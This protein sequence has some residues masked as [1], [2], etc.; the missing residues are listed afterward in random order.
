VAATLGIVV[1]FIGGLTQLAILN[2]SVVRA[3]QLG[4]TPFAALDLVKAFIAAVISGSSTSS[5]VARQSD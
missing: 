5:A 4:I 2:G 1:V 3:V